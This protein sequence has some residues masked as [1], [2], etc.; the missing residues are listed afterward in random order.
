MLT[1]SWTGGAYGHLKALETCRIRKS[2]SFS[3]GKKVF[4]FWQWDYCRC[5]QKIETLVENPWTKVAFLFCTI[6]PFKVVGES[7]G[8]LTFICK[9]ALPAIAPFIINDM[10][11]HQ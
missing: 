3:D 7:K 4:L 1:L 10:R 8:A 5:T 2:D 9:I 6:D 11:S